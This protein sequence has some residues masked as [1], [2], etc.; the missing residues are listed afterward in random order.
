MLI[1][2]PF[3]T[4]L[5]LQICPSLLPPHILSST[6]TLPYPF[7]LSLSSPFLFLYFS[8]SPLTPTAHP[9]YLPTACSVFWMLWRSLSSTPAP[10]PH[11]LLADSSVFTLFIFGTQSRWQLY[12]EQT[13]MP[14]SLC[15]ATP[16]HRFPLTKTECGSRVV[17]KRRAQLSRSWDPAARPE[18]QPSL[19]RMLNQPVSILNLKAISS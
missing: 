8:S 2:S 19:G 6:S 12:Q 16:V 11:T 1:P 14:A 18:Q 15:L 13:Q 17:G 4:L 3:P 7:L 5:L 9:R 10:D